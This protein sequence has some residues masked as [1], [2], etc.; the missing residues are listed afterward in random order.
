MNR[1]KPRP[2][3]ATGENTPS[4]TQT[5]KEEPKGGKEEKAEKEED[6]PTIEEMDVD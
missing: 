3:V 5:P 4:G 6:G 1:P 2:K